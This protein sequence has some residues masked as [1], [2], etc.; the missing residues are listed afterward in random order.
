[1]YLIGKYS[2]DNVNCTE[3]VAHDAVD[4]VE[5]NSR[6]EKTWLSRLFVYP[7]HKALVY[8]LDLLRPEKKHGTL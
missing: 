8:T 6:R 3:V 2:W 7:F 5:E 4:A 1:M